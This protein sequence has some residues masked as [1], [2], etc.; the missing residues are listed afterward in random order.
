MLH[1]LD[2][3]GGAAAQSKERGDKKAAAEVRVSES[4]DQADSLAAGPA[5]AAED[6]LM[7][8]DAGEQ[9]EAQSER[10]EDEGAQGSGPAPS[11]RRS[12]RLSSATPPADS[13][14]EAGSDAEESQK[15]GGAVRRSARVSRVASTPAAVK[16]LKQET[17]SSV[18][19]ER[20][21][22]R[23]QT[24]KSEPA[25]S[26]IKPSL[27]RVFPQA[28]LLQDDQEPRWAWSQTNDNEKLQTVHF[29][30]RLSTMMPFLEV[31]QTALDHGAP[32]L[33]A[34]DCYDAQTIRAALNERALEPSQYQVAYIMDLG[35][36]NNNGIERANTQDVSTAA[37]EIGKDRQWA[38][39]PADYSFDEIDADWMSLARP[40][41]LSHK[42]GGMRK[43]FTQRGY[44]KDVS[45]RVGFND[46]HISS[47]V[48]FPTLD[49][50][51]RELKLGE[52][53]QTDRDGGEQAEPIGSKAEFIARR[54]QLRQ[55]RRRL[56]QLKGKKGFLIHPL[57]LNELQLHRQSLINLSPVEFEGVSSYYLYLKI[58]FQFFNL[59]R[60]T[61][62]KRTHGPARMRTLH[63]SIRR[64][65]SVHG[66]RAPV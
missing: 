48:F 34:P 64:L 61:T 22:S 42:Y 6:S 31:V 4:E 60:Q 44:F 40:K 33:V 49:A 5:P 36:G 24:L 55:H 45:E 20:T 8:E 51:L 32:V 10:D 62:S 14:S 41:E 46:K 43:E 58:G 13:T 12:Q 11:A 65:L 27:Q 30:G 25:S 18:K 3:D 28:K 35:C 57:F 37:I 52:D 47:R 19:Q 59:V 1:P 66:V 29:A 53:E 56:E 39:N 9:K 15:K 16:E 17:T 38:G 26:N 7:P 50:A 23:R 63:L 2:T 54:K 21:G